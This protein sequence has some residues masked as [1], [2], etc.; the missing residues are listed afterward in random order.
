MNTVYPIKDPETVNRILR[1]LEQDKTWHGQRMY[2]LFATGVYTGLRV[3][4]LV[5]LRVGNVQGEYIRLKEQKTGKQ[6]SIY[7]NRALG[8]IF[9][10]RLKGMAPDAFIFASRKRDTNGEQKPI[11]TR[12]AAYDMQLIKRRFGI[13]DPFAC[14][15]MRKTFGYRMY[16][17]GQGATLEELRQM[18][19]HSKEAVTRRYIGVD[20]E[21]RNKH[22]KKLDFGGYM[23]QNSPQR[24]R[25]RDA[26]GG[27]ALETSWRH[28]DQHGQG[29][30][31]EPDKEPDKGQ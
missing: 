6:Q 9:D 2:L 5:R 17:G 11:T 24:A 29:P 14:H 15:S 8:A 20:E 1:E 12:A 26:H 22:V 30:D 25:R 10:A 13:T 27:E 16:N 7:I 3:S 23:P 31:K 4:D 19:N 28:S 18:F 21:L